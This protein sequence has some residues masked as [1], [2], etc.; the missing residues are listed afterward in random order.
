VLPAGTPVM[1]EYYKPKEMWPAESQE[2]F[3]ALRGK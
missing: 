2:R 1:H 3:A